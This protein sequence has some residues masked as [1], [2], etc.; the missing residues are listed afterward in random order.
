[1]VSCSFRVKVYSITQGCWLRKHL[2]CKGNKHIPSK[3]RN[4][5]LSLGAKKTNSCFSRA[6]R[7]KTSNDQIA[8]LYI[9]YYTRGKKKEPKFEKEE[10]KGPTLGDLFPDLFEKL[11]NEL[12]EE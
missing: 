4:L 10:F 6:V 1:M 11:R 3:I 9:Y 8:V 7:Y 2:K 12:D 5:I